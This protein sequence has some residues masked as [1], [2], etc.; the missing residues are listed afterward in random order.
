MSVMPCLGDQEF[1]ISGE[2][3]GVQFA[4]VVI[5]ARHHG[6]VVYL[7]LGAIVS[8]GS[9][10]AEVI[11]VSRLRLPIAAAQVLHQALGDQITQ[12]LKPV[13]KSRAN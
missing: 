13:D 4:E 8:E 1:R 6:G 2:S 9:G 11:P 10:D 12:A 5:D 3:L 7:T